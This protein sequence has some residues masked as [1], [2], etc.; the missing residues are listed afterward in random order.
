M[1]DVLCAGIDH[2]LY[3]HVYAYDKSYLVREVIPHP[4]SARSAEIKVFGDFVTNNAYQGVFG[5]ISGST[6]PSI[7][8]F[9]FK[10]TAYFRD[11]TFE[12]P[13]SGSVRMRNKC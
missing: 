12:M 9:Q 11:N 10:D 1:R 3:Y 2:V 6:E 7:I 5:S 8:H 4:A 13:I